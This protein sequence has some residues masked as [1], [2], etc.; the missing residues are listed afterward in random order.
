[1]LGSLCLVA[2]V[3]QNDLDAPLQDWTP[4]I[5]SKTDNFC[6][7]EVATEVRLADDRVI[8]GGG[9]D[10][11]VIASIKTDFPGQVTPETICMAMRAPDGTIRK[12]A[13]YREAE[14]ALMGAIAGLQDCG[15]G[16]R[17]IT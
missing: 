11:L 10:Y 12:F 15:H 1:M 17:Y 6:D 4:A 9:W 5:V 8:V 3:D 7:L 14:A 13:R 2:K 16:T